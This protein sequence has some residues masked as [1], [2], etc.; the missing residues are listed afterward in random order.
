MSPDEIA[1]RLND[2]FDLLTSGNRTALP[3]HQTLRATID[4]S[5]DLLSETEKVLFRR[6]S[7]FVG[8]FTLEAAEAITGG[9]DISESQVVSLLERLVN[10]S[11]IVVEASSGDQEDET[12]YRMLETIREYAYEKLEYEGGKDAM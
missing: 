1:L 9:G 4:W 11:L 7:V 3:R 10:K 5:Y 12:R 2:R 8:G 6:L